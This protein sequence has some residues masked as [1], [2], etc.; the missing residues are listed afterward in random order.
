MM[1]FCRVA[2]ATSVVFLAATANAAETL[3]F[4]EVAEGK[5]LNKW[6]EIYNPTDEPVLLS[7]IR[8][9]QPSRSFRGENNDASLVLGSVGGAQSDV[10]EANSHIIVCNEGLIDEKEC[11][12]RPR[13][14]G[15]YVLSYN[16]NDALDLYVNDI[17]VDR[18]GTVGS[19]EA[20]TV[21][22]QTDAGEDVT[23]VRK[24]DVCQG[25]VEDLASFAE[26]KCEWI[27]KGRDNFDDFNLHSP[28]CG[29]IFCGTVNPHVYLCQPINYGATC[30]LVRVEV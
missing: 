12:L 24:P 23:L 4:A 18:F 30:L 22:G 29:K 7:N 9:V 14:T 20:F 27:I 26:D 28:N 13:N 6:F 10:L 11:D 3:F 15:K 5:G 16:G 25:N 17:L 1:G 19:R 8:V 21:C 2:A